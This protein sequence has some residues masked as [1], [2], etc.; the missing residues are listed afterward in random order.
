MSEGTV[1]RYAKKQCKLHGIFWRKIK[2]A[3]VDGCPDSLLAYKGHSI[4]IEYKNDNKRGRLSEMQKHQIQH[5]RKAGLDIRVIDSKEGI[6]NVV[7]ELI[8]A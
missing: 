6:D 5:M 2:F 3:G 4:F 7:R 8:G 1:Q